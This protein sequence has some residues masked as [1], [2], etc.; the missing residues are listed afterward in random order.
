MSGVNKGGNIYYCYKPVNSEI[1]G[2]SYEDKLKKYAP[3]GYDNLLSIICKVI[4]L[5][6]N[7]VTIKNKNIKTICEKYFPTKLYKTSE[8]FNNSLS[9]GVRDNLHCKL[10]YEL[11]SYL[12]NGDSLRENLSKNIK[13]FEEFNEI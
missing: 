11:I 2:G 5:G 1:G 13:Q 7:S 10:H 6:S 4:T 3:R 12:L 9:V 8:D